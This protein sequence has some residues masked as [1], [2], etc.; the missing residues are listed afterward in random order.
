MLQMRDGLVDL[1]C[2]DYSVHAKLY[3]SAFFLLLLFDVINSLEFPDPES[4]RAKSCH[5]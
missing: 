1:Q 3:F 5:W 4:V 2:N